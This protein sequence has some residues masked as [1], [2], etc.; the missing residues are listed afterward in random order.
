MIK[1]CTFLTDTNKFYIILR[2]FIVT[3]KSLHDCPV[4]K[5]LSFC[6][7]YQKFISISSWDWGSVDQLDPLRQTLWPGGHHVRVSH[8]LGQFLGLAVPRVLE[9]PEVVIVL[10]AVAVAVVLVLL[11]LKD[12]TFENI[13]ESREY[14][15]SP[16]PKKNCSWALPAPCTVP[17]GASDSSSSWNPCPCSSPGLGSC[18]DPWLC[19]G[20]RI[21]HSSRSHRSNHHSHS[22]R[23]HSSAPQHCK[24]PS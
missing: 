8:G 20:S 3:V 9:V 13:V 17:W 23:G 21:C 16:E 7:V 2:F 10:P 5:V 24:M 19:L 12:K 1:Y 14:S 15:S 4:T 11:L 22:S 6:L 18:R